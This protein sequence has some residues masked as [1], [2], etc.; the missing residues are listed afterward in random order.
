MVGKRGGGG[1]LAP[2]PVSGGGGE[3]KE[4]MAV[5]EDDI[6]HGGGGGGG[7]GVDCTSAPRDGGGAGELPA[8]GIWGEGFPTGTF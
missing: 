4:F 1:R 5:K 8:I 6:S 7:D 3:G 2:T